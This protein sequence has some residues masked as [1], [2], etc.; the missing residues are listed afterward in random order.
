MWIKDKGP[1][2]QPASDL[3]RISI[4]RATFCRIKDICAKSYVSNT[5]V[6]VSREMAY[7]LIMKPKYSIRRQL[8]NIGEDVAVQFLTRRG[9]KIRERNYLKPWGE[10]DI[11]AENSGVIR[12]VEVKTISRATSGNVARESNGY[13]PEE[14]VHPAKLQKLSR[15]AETYVNERGI[16]QGYQIDVVAVFLDT[17]TRKAHCR[18]YEQVL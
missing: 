1:I 16:D 6:G 12:F 14:Q 9:F 10:I 5:D 8:G 2:H 13:R 11:V 7:N 18:L 17:A 15:M 3:P 4:C